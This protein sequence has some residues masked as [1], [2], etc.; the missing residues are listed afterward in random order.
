MGQS[1]GLQKD[2]V[3]VREW[4]YGGSVNNSKQ[5]HAV[6]EGGRQVKLVHTCLNYSMPHVNTMKAALCLDST[7]GMQADVVHVQMS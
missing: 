1:S 4:R 3:G 5:S 6:Y 7:A 2:S